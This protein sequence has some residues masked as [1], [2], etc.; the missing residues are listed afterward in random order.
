MVLEF[1]Y[2]CLH[3]IYGPDDSKMTEV[4]DIENC[5]RDEI[6]K[7]NKG[8]RHKTH[9]RFRAVKGNLAKYVQ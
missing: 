3:D 6:H 1:R 4:E 9:L 8:F 5:C 7:C 2:R